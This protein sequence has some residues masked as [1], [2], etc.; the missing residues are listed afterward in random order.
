ME[1]TIIDLL[2]IMVIDDQKAMRSIIKRLLSQQ[3]IKN[4]SEAEN[5]KHALDLLRT[6]QV[7]LPDV[8][9]CDLY[10]DG[11]DGMEFVTFLRRHKINVPVLILTGEQD[12]FVLDVARQAGATNVLKKPIS[13]P[14][15][16]KE[17][18]NAVGAK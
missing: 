1:A 5:G 7:V 10:M 6:G 18:Q 17:I 2:R 15:L 11:M 14:D 8:I 4:V 9:I 13:G 12:E 3:N 16:Y